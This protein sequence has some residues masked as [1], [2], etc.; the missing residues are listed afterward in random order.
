MPPSK[1]APGRLASERNVSA[2]FIPPRT[3]AELASPAAKGCRHEQAKKIALSLLGQQLTPEAVFM[4]LRMTYEPDVSDREIHDLVRWAVSKNPQ[5]C[6]YCYAPRNFARPSR[7]E[8][9]SAEQAALNAEKWLGGFRCDEWDLWHVSPWRPSEDWRL[10]SM[11]LFAALYEQAERV[12]IVTDYTIA[13]EGDERQ[14]ASPKGAGKIMLRDKWLRHIREHGTPESAAGS[15]IRLNPV[16]SGGGGTGGAITD[17][18]VSSYRF[19]LVESDA[20]ALENQLSLWARLPLPVAAIISSGGASY[21]AWVKVDCTDDAEYR[22]QV[23]CI[24]TTLAPFA[25][26]PA[27]KNPSRLARLPGAQ[28]SI[29]AYG[30]GAQRLVYLNPE[31]TGE[32]IFPK[33]QMS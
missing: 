29:G 15:W 12:N 25:V 19:A 7:P 21:H 9:V 2:L 32:P 20:L 10:D 3:R 33:G 4:Q 1:K 27:N 5:P 30:D 14:K 26:D 23:N 8:R 17:L 16:K 22:E 28:R 24:F 31:P 13:G 18:D 6:G 11:M